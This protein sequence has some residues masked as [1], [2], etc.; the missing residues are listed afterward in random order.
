MSLVCTQGHRGFV[1]QE[2]AAQYAAA[3]RLSGVS[4]GI[5][6]QSGMVL[7]SQHASSS[8]QRVSGDAL[9]PAFHEQRRLSHLNIGSP[10]GTVLPDPSQF[11]MSP[12]QHLSQE[13]LH[14]SQQLLAPDPLPSYMMCSTANNKLLEQH[15]RSSHQSMAPSLY[16]KHQELKHAVGRLSEQKNAQV[17]SRHQVLLD[18]QRHS[19]QKHSNMLSPT[20]FNSPVFGLPAFNLDQQASSRVPSVDVPQQSSLIRME[21]FNDTKPLTHKNEAQHIVPMVETKFHQLLR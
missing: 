16:H 3:A 20:G 5:M 14:P 17:F 18:E 7:P 10:Q 9:S 11:G 1:S 8:L 13:T 15:F 6:Q 21:S 2:R 4:S 12:L 19:P